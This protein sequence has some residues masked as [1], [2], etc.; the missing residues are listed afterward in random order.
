[1][2]TTS[3]M[4]GD[5]FKVYFL[6]ERY[7]FL[8]LL[9][10]LET[11][12]F[13]VLSPEQ[14]SLRFIKDND[15]FYELSSM[16]RSDG[17]KTHPV[18]K[19]KYK[20]Q[21]RY[22]EEIK[23]CLSKGLKYP[24]TN[25]ETLSL[26]NLFENYLAGLHIKFSYGGCPDKDSR[27]KKDKKVLEELQ[28]MVEGQ[29]G[30]SKLTDL[31]K[32]SIEKTINKINR[33]NGSYSDELVRA[34]K[35]NLE[36]HKGFSVKYSEKIRNVITDINDKRDLIKNLENEIAELALMVNVEHKDLLLKDVNGWD[37]TPSDVKE[38]LSIVIKDIE[39]VGLIRFPMSH[40]DGKIII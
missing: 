29:D 26:D 28:V 10:P 30:I 13:V 5:L 19:A 20:I 12:D 9:R 40:N 25:S 37:N 14:Q 34:V 8:E 16:T 38:R 36:Y 7:Y 32:N 4:I 18:Y 2:S 22:S 6:W 3:V 23:E 11:K 27:D 33:L 1:M 31:Y 21:F 15:W 35:N 17:A 24:H 39:M